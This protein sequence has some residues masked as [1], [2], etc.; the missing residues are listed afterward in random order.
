MPLNFSEGYVCPFLCLPPSPL[1]CTH[2]AHKELNQ[3]VTYSDPR[4]KGDGIERPQNNET[5]RNFGGYLQPKPCMVTGDLRGEV[6]HRSNSK[7]RTR[8][9]SSIPVPFAF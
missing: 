2:C 6:T 1:S 8:P 4:W 5:R 9:R 3:I 7:V